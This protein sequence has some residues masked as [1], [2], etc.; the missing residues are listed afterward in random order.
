MIRGIKE[1][2]LVDPHTTSTSESCRYKASRRCSTVA[3][4][5]WPHGSASCARRPARAV[6]PQVDVRLIAGHALAS[7][8]RTLKAADQFLALAGEHGAGDDFEHA[9]GLSLHGLA[10]ASL[11]GVD[12]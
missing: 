6:V 8:A 11:S 12:T 5:S 7:D 9:G 3:T 2:H 4:S 1:L 10:V